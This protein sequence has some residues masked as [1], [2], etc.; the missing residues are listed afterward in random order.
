MSRKQFTFALIALAIVGTA[1]LLLLKHN[2]KAWSVREARVGDKVFPNFSV[3]DVSAIHIKSSGS[4]FTVERKDSLWRVR[5]RGDYPA[6]YQQIKDLLLRMRDIKVIQSDTVGPAQLSRVGLEAPE[7]HVSEVSPAKSNTSATLVE[8]KNTHGNLLNA[9][10]VGKRH[11][12][13]ERKSD[14]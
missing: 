6:N 10:L 9:T 1:G 13:P 11:V 3:N 7:E 4:D 14:P 12:R 8:F 2:Q 5:E